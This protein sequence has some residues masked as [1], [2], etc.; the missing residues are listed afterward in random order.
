MSLADSRLILS[1]T[2]TFGLEPETDPVIEVG[3]VITD[4]EFNILSSIAVQIWDGEIYDRR[5]AEIRDAA[6]HENDPKKRI[7]W[8]MHRKN[9]LWDDAMDV[10]V[11]LREASSVLQ[12]W[13]LE[14]LV[15]GQDPL[16]GS[17]ID[18]DRRM[19]ARWMPE[20]EKRFHYRTINI[21]SI[22]E[23]CRRYNPEMYSHLA[24]D[25]ENRK[26]HRVIPDIHDSIRE[27]KWYVENFLFVPGGKFDD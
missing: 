6:E 5:Y 13:L 8:D 24:E 23:L 27:L 9:G 22:K 12:N 14:N 17:T 2:E 11:S 21:S 20:V 3:F 7:V 26:E 16:V 18:F 19:L 10:G 4:L 15:N 1:D 25:V